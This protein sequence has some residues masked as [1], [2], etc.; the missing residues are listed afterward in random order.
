M[1]ATANRGSTRERLINA[2]LRLFAEQGYRTTTVG[3]IEAA[4]GLAP[5][6]GALYRHFPSKHALLE[7]AVRRH[8]EDVTGARSQFLSPALGDLR[9]EAVLAG[10]VILDTLDAQRDISHL[11]ERDG[12]LVEELRDAF[13]REV[14]DFSYR[15][16]LTLL[17]R[18]IGADTPA[19]DAESWAV[20]LLGALINVRRSAW[21]LGAPPLDV[22]DERHVQAWADMCVGLVHT[23][24]DEGP[25]P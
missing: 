2:G 3:E 15:V 4:A 20:L 24:R 25:T 1:D 9:A 6:R 18:W 23:A 16:M 7:A 14:S 8:I 10:H 12:A 13:R 22:D 11:F 5:R 19:V 21:T 17:R